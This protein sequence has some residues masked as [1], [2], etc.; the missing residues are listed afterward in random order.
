[1]WSD[2][3]RLLCC[4]SGVLTWAARVVCGTGAARLQ[5]LNN[6]FRSDRRRCVCAAR[7]C[8][9]FRQEKESPDCGPLLCYDEAKLEWHRRIHWGRRT[10]ESVFENCIRCQNDVNYAEKLRTF[11]MGAFCD[12]D[13]CDKMQPFHELDMCAEAEKRGSYAEITEPEIKAA[14][15]DGDPAAAD[16]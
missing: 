13:I 8:A 3:P 11:C 14:V 4:S 16:G 9:I 1:M 15:P 10:L 12:T 7:F 2:L 5:L 6:S